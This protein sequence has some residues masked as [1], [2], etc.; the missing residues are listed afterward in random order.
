MET[1]NGLIQANNMAMNENQEQIRRINNQA[2][3][4]PITERQLLGIERQ[5]KLNDEL[6]TFLLEKRAEQQIQKASNVP[7][8]E[9]ID[10]ADELDHT[11]VSPNKPAIYLLGWFSGIALP[12]LIILTL[13]SLNKTIKEE[14]IKQ[15]TDFPISGNIPR[16]N[17]KITNVVLDHPE[18]SIAEAFRL[19]RSRMQF[20]I[21]ETKSPIILVTSSL[22]E[23]GKTF[24]AI[25]LASVYSIMGK[26]TVLVG[27]DLRKPKIYGDFNLSNT[28]GVSSWII[29][30][31]TLKDITQKTNYE[32]LFVITAGPIPPNPSELT[33][34]PKTEE[35]LTQLKKIFDYI[36]IDTSP[37]GIVSDTYHL[38][39]MADCCLLVVR[40]D[41]TLRD[42]FE[43][44]LRE[45]RT[46]E[47]KD[48]SLVINDVLIDEKRYGYGAR[49]GYT[50]S[51]AELKKNKKD[52]VNNNVISR[53]KALSIRKKTISANNKIPTNE[54]K[55]N[56]RNDL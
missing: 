51:E 23:D 45:I 19:L 4:L 47:I 27:F 21:K 25:N 9:M 46:S 32:N 48:L 18:T 14:E 2:S 36:I 6:Y 52:K 31:D 28:K 29:G 35:L 10:Y 15:I 56:M 54:W 44:T 42:I 39:S 5:F 37:I 13:Y 33:S 17:L 1:L 26:K 34:L 53:I 11:I 41:K 7:D 43:K 50:K 20:F 38:A 3:T 30:K 12:F 16:N 49:Y 22:P 8:N 40:Q 55:S 24:I